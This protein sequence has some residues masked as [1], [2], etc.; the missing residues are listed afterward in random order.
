MHRA[1]WLVLAVVLG[2]GATAPPPAAASACTLDN[3]PAATLLLPY[4][5]VD[6]DSLSGTTT[7]FSIHNAWPEATVAHIIFWTDWGA[8]TINFDVFL[9][10]YDVV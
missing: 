8:P 3:V 10:G 9:T 5:E 1:P 6:L 7:V 4:F 2:I